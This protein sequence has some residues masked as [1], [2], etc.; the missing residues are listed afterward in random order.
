MSP[1]DRSRILNRVADL[2][3]ERLEELAVLETRDNGKPIE[4]SRAD[5][6][7]SARV[8]RYYAG[9]PSR[10]T[11]TVVPVDA[12]HHVYDARAGGS[13][14]ADPAVELPDHDGELQAGAGARRRLPWW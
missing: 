2:I 10:L 1:H 12:Q 8:F 3:E 6:A 7:T 11:G 5:T 9:A 14:G 4:R 13:G